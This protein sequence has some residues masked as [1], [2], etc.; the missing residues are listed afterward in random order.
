MPNENSHSWWLDLRHGGML[1]APVLLEEV[2]PMGFVQP[3]EWK[4]RLLR[5]RFAKFA[6]WWD[7]EERSE[8]QLKPT[9]E[10]IEYV[11]EH[12]LDLSSGKW[13]KGSQIPD[14]FTATTILR[15]K[16]RP[17]RLYFKE[18]NSPTPLFAV[19]VDGAPRLGIG[20]SRK[21]YGR[22]LQYLRARSIKLGI[23]TN[24]VQLRLCYAGLDH[25]SWVEWDVANWFEKGEFIPQLYGLFTLLGPSGIDA[26]D[27][28]EIPLLHAI[29]SSRS[30]QGEL[31]SV[32]G[33]Q[34]RQAIELLVDE[35]NKTREKD[36]SFI[37][38]IRKSPDGSV[39]SE[40]VVLAA[41]F[42][43]SV[44]II[45]RMVVVL[46][47]EARDLLPRS[48]ERY[49]AHY[50]IE[51]LFE[52][53]RRARSSES[54]SFLDDT[55]SEWLRLLGLFRLIYFGS[56]HQDIQIPRYGGELFAPG[57]VDSHEPIERA[58]ALYEDIRLEVR[59][60][61]LLAILEKLKYGK[62]KIKKG[63]SSTFVRG[64]VNF[65]ELRTE[66]IGM[67]YEGIL[68]YGLRSASETMV[69]INA[70]MEP[71]L[72]LSVL[73]TLTDAQVKELFEKLKEK[74]KSEDEEIEQVDTVDSD[75]PELGDDVSEDEVEPE[76]EIQS[77]TI[78]T[79]D[80][81][82][83]AQKWAERAVVAI[84][85]IKRPKRQ[86]DQYDFQNKLRQKARSLVK[87]VYIPGEYYL[88]LW[89]GTRKGTGTFYT[90]PQLA[91]PT[92]QRTLEPLVYETDEQGNKIPKLPEVILSLKVCDSSCGSASFLVAATHYLTEGLYQSLAYHAALTD[93]N[94]YKRKT[95]PL[96]LKVDSPT[97]DFMIPC[98]PE[99][100]A[101][102]EKVKARLRRSV[103]E[104]CIYGVDLN[105]MAIEL[106][107]LSLWIET[108][109]KDLPFEF[110]DHKIKTGNSL[111]G[112]WLDTF[113]EYPLA[114]WL[115]E[116]GDKSHPTSVHFKEGAW[117]KA[118]K[119]KFQNQIKSEMVSVIRSRSGQEQFS[120]MGEKIEPRGIH[121]ELLE[122]FNSLHDQA[123]TFL[124]LEQKEKIYTEQIVRNPHYLRLKDAMDLWCSLWFWPADKLDDAPTPRVFYTP[125]ESTLSI[126]RR[127]A[128]QQR[129]FHWELEFPDVFNIGRNGFDAMLG[130]PPWEISKPNSK[131]FFSRIDPM[132][133]SY[134]KQ[135]ALAQQKRFFSANTLLEYDWL[136]YYS[137]FKWLSNFVK[138]AFAPF[139]DPSEY[140]DNE[141]ILARG[142]ENIG[143]HSIWRLKRKAHIGFA[144]PTH[145][146]RY[147]G[148]AD[149]NLYKLF[150]E[151]SY[152]LSKDRGHI[153][154]IVPSGVY[155]DKGSKHLRSLFIDQSKWEWLYSFENKEAIFD[156]HR[157]YKFN[158]MIIIKGSETTTIKTAFMRHNVQ[159]WETAEGVLD[160]SI[161]SIKKLSPFNL[162]L[163]EI[164]HR[165]DAE[166]IEK[167]YSNSVLLGDKSPDGWGLEYAT[168]FHMTSDSKYFYSRLKLLEKGYKQDFYGRLIGPD[169]D[170]MLPLY[171]GVMIW[172]FD[173]SAAGYISGAGNR[174]KW[175][176]I[177]WENKT[178]EAQFY[179]SGK[180][181]YFGQHTRLVIRAIQ[182]AT[183]ERTLIATIIPDF[184][185]GN[186]LA[187]L[188]EGS[189][190]RNLILAGILNS[191]PID[192][193]LRKRMSQNNVNSY[194]I[195]E[196]PVPKPKMESSIQ[197]YICE[198]SASL[199]LANKIY[200]P[201]WV[202]LDDGK[203]NIQYKKWSISNSER[204][205]K[206]SIID[207][208]VAEIYGLQLEDLEWLVRDDK[209]ELKGFWRV[210]QNN[211]KEL[212]HTTLALQAFKR[213]KE[214]GIEEFLKEDWQLPLNVQKALGPRFYDWQMQGTPEDSWAECEYHA[215]QILGEEG[216]NQFMKELEEGKQ[217]TGIVKEPTAKYS[218]K[219]VKDK[220]QLT[221][222]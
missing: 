23:F 176:D 178:I 84:G 127:I 118:I 72:P 169:G 78:E 208:L 143:L 75:Q 41:I 160:Y 87:R 42:Q 139:G 163:L 12:F 161:E 6:S 30:R 79:S 38:P 219:K 153:G 56:P 73:E 173:F 22:M 88:S 80:E 26:R 115:R 220:D 218:S 158:P 122:A 128:Q 188:F 8:S 138:N 141:I 117:T 111:V 1:I 101:F 55:T 35:F 67:I 74:D 152:T 199:I 166:I 95:L 222:I 108:M 184:P 110:I 44:R 221:L 146:F 107:R 112:T 81:L 116:G 34:I 150:L 71:I 43:A 11:F 104:H 198:L 216:Y 131:E 102:E 195:E 53:L 19:F 106:A 123:A 51:G 215:R 210:D 182:N 52:N 24:G 18:K 177:G 32:L 119:E 155:S 10:W 180:D 70:G 91:V 213:L 159:D 189:I 129:F 172:Q 17:H 217:E 162:S 33:E 151:E 135:E 83:R 187:I 124:G 96:G 29:E 64:P 133:R 5:E 58:L 20:R 69:L 149:L 21:N 164:T 132:Y 193:I 186:S 168:E 98:S 40:E 203:K 212:R 174:A 165:R 77:V 27:D 25:E 90:R 140:E 202:E 92:V 50:G 148:S 201:F 167:I 48:H 28:H 39:I 103:V 134:G 136:I 211:P 15:E 76:E 175:R 157:S 45:M 214:V 61:T 171:Q 85:W 66:Y 82:I 99:E 130:N 86:I 137:R 7:G 191:F 125:S 47:A 185:C 181:K 194:L 190:Q 31:S 60:G 147:Q 204:L 14:E 197:E 113:Q 3:S 126:S 93:P 37:D 154:I 156:I 209:S 142:K 49:N 36:P 196:L 120:F 192:L 2:F 121:K 207:A 105:P 57:R 97:A 109:D 170:V 54:S 13:L 63:R 94:D 4:V 62:L 46:F 16:I 145:P 59:N 89:G 100:D 200:S 114:A 205:R 206:R 179:I 9:H 68:D 183:N 65:G 144:A